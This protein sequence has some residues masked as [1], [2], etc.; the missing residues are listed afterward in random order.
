VAIGVAWHSHPGLGVTAAVVRVKGRADFVM[1]DLLVVDDDLD[2]PSS[3]PTCSTCRVTGCAPPDLAV[4][5]K[6][7]AVPITEEVLH[8][9][10]RH[11]AEVRCKPGARLADNTI[12][13][14]IDELL[15]GR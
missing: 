12:G 10:M 8:A 6:P 15:R 14:V 13:G 11:Q 2:T 3:S 7:I 5:K 4:V 9:L 1:P